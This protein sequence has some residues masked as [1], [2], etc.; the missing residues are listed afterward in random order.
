MRSWPFRRSTLNSSTRS[1]RSRV[2]G[3]STRGGRSTS[4]VMGWVACMYLGTVALDGRLEHR[5]T[6]G[7]GEADCQNPVQ[8]VQ[9]QGALAEVWC[10][11]GSMDR[12][13]MAVRGATGLLFGRPLDINRARQ[14]DWESLPGIG[15]ARASAILKYRERSP[16]RSLD[17]LRQVHGIG[18]KTVAG[19]AGW[20][21]LRESSRGPEANLTTKD[22]GHPLR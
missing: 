7:D 10:N 4:S 12:G 18:K 5:P 9:P 8:S 20:V 17:E 16:F 15:P 22:P 2:P 11:G 6:D 3:E 13:R 19:L 1:K 14:V 21:E